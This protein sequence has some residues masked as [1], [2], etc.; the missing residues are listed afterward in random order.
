MLMLLVPGLIVVVLLL[1]ALIGGSLLISRDDFIFA[2]PGG[3]ES[4]SL[5][6]V[7]PDLRRECG[8]C[9]PLSETSLRMEPS[10]TPAE[11]E[12]SGVEVRH[13]IKAR[14]SDSV[15]RAIRQKRK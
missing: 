12:G 15:I 6:A 13:P 10:R 7:F 11:T 2:V 9:F 5:S 14:V 3:K 8:S 1:A 4:W